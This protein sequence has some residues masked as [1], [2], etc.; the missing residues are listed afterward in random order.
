MFSDVLSEVK[1]LQ[2][3]LPSYSVRCT[4]HS[5]GTTHSNSSQFP[6]LINPP[7]A[8]LALLT[9]MDLANNGIPNS[10]Y[11]YGQ[12]RVGDSQFATCS[13]SKITVERVTHLKDP[14]PHIPF[15][16]WNY[17]HGCRE[18]YE[19]SSTATNPQVLRAFWDSIFLFVLSSNLFG[20]CR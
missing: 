14:V 10:V 18:A 13:S 6:S 11:N 17:V 19:S 8:A 9:S 16:S 12:P 4:G 2:A 1:R 5:L 15:E 7:G 3:E 20:K